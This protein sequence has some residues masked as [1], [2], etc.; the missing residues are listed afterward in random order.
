MGSQSWTG[1]SDFH[2]HLGFPGGSDS[3]TVCLQC[4]RPEF[5]PWVRKFLPGKSHEQRS[6]GGYSPWGH[7]ESGTAE[8]LHIAEFITRNAGLPESQAGIKIARRNINYLRYADDTI[9]RAE[10]RGTKELLEGE[11]G[12]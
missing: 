12:E 9:L 8:Q 10:R 5:D 4:R 2:F 1:L 7:K 11:R 3:K 6:L